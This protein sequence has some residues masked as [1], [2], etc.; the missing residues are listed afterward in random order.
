MDRMDHNMNDRRNDEGNEANMEQDAQGAQGAQGGREGGEPEVDL[1]GNA[2]ARPS[3]WAVYRCAG[4]DTLDFEDQLNEAGVQAWTP[5]CWVSRRVPRRRTKVWKLAPVMGSYLFVSIDDADQIPG[6][7]W[8]IR[9]L[10]KAMVIQGQFVI[11]ADRDLDGLREFD[12]RDPPQ[13]RRKGRLPDPGTPQV[14]P[15]P[16]FQVGQTVFVKGVLGGIEAEVLARTPGGEYTV[17]PKNSPIKVTVSGFM[18]EQVGVYR[19]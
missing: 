12:R 18:L 14:P 7:P 15:P 8:S 19:G 1:A 2:P 10:G 5:R 9:G 17:A 3:E 6:L 16:V 4:P 13:P 11:V